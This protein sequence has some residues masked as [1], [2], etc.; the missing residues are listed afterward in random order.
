MTCDITKVREPVLV[1]Q[2]ASTRVTWK[3]YCK[4]TVRLDVAGK[5][6]TDLWQDNYCK[7]LDIC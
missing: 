5:E 6:E 4:H 3:A 7:Y 1:Q 2:S